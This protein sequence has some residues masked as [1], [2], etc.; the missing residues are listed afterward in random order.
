MKRNS[1]YKMIDWKSYNKDNIN[2]TIPLLITGLKSVG[3][4]YLAYD[5]AR[6]FFNYTYYFNFEL[7]IKNSGFFNNNINN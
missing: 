7:D 3:K 1:I 2:K 5:Y 4:T 6:I